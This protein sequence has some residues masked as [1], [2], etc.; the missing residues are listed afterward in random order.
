MT[1]LGGEGIPLSSR[2]VGKVRITLEQSRAYMPEPSH[3]SGTR[4]ALQGW[5]TF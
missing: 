4:A 5:L 2:L 3:T 1:G